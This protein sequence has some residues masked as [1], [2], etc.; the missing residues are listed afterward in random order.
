MELKPVRLLEI[1]ALAEANFEWLLA[2]REGRLQSTSWCVE[3]ADVHRHLQVFDDE[4]QLHMAARRP[5]T[6]LEEGMKLPRRVLG[7]ALHV[8]T[9]SPEV[10]RAAEALLSLV[11]VVPRLLTR[12][13]TLAITLVADRASRNPQP[14]VGRHVEPA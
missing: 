3:Y 6:V 4:I 8:A 13:L 10:E 1:D 5:K 12:D 11:D 14:I 7:A 9:S 2:E